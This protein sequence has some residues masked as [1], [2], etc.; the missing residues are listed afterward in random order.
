MDLFD[1][2]APVDDDDPIVG[3][4]SREIAVEERQGMLHLVLLVELRELAARL[5]TGGGGVARQI[6]DDGEMRPQ[7]VSVAG[8]S[9][10]ERG[11]R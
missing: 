5:A 4:V 6:E 2:A 3:H 7:G 11:T 10:W 8:A 1:R 9:R